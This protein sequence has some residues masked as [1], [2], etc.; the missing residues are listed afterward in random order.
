MI[1]KI[2]Q[3]LGLIIFLTAIF[4]GNQYYQTHIDSGQPTVVNKAPS[5]KYTQ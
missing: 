1:S 2:L 5:S 3:A 4:F